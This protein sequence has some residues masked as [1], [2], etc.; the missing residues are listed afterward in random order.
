MKETSTW[1]FH[2]SHRCAVPLPSQSHRPPT[3]AENHLRLLG[4]TCV[5]PLWSAQFC[6][7]LTRWNSQKSSLVF[8]PCIFRCVSRD[9]NKQELFLF[10]WSAG[11]HGKKILRET[12][13]H[14]SRDGF[15]LKKTKTKT[16][17]MN[18]AHFSD[19]GRL[20][21]FKTWGLDPK[22][23]EHM[24]SP[25]YVFTLS[26]FQNSRLSFFQ[27]AENDVKQVTSI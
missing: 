19:W 3:H 15:V 20:D 2:V 6:P 1:S 21:I 4:S 11:Q 24:F 9:T 25:K 22:N 10:S 7:R 18:A 16:C 5:T 17:W 26:E 13:L 27:L 23:F 14:D 12:T 8:Q